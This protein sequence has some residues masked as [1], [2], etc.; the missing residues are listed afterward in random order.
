M[1]YGFPAANYFAGPIGIG[2]EGGSEFTEC[3][4][5]KAVFVKQIGFWFNKL[6]LQAIQITYTDD[7]ESKTYGTKHNDYKELT[8]GDKETIT[9]AALWGNRTGIRAGRIE[10]DTSGGQN[11]WAGKD[12]K[13][14]QMYPVKTGSG[15]LAGFCGR[16]GYDIDM[17]CLIFLR[18]VTRIETSEFKYRNL[19]SGPEL[20]KQGIEKKCLKT[21][22]VKNDTA[23]ADIPR[24]FS[25]AVT[26][27]DTYS[28][29][30][31]KTHQVGAKLG[32]KLTGKLEAGIPVSN[33]GRSGLGSVSRSQLFLHDVG[34]ENRPQDLYA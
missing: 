12:V 22:T 29:S 3:K 15:I 7:T 26:V 23:A 18:P 11:F 24:K 34:T 13:G 33:Q 5:E 9:R 30:N 14:Q 28:I 1:G 19:K 25:E 16:S 17:L 32:G 4:A 27:T 10:L 20:S 6:G 31:T 21:T 2:G 8:L